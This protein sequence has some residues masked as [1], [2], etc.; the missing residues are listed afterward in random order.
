MLIHFLYYVG[1]Y[2]NLCS[3]HDWPLLYVLDT[4]WT[5]QSTAEMGLLCHFARLMGR[6]MQIRTLLPSST[7]QE[8]LLLFTRTTT[9]RPAY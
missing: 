4:M 8:S 9:P 6:R 2:Y 5:H 1:D 3:Y 7:L